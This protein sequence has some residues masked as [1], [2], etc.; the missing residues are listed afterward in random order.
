MRSG[1]VN[2]FAIM[3]FVTSDFRSTSLFQLAIAADEAGDMFRPN[4]TAC[5]VALCTVKSL[6]QCHSADQFSV[7]IIPASSFARSLRKLQ[8]LTPKCIAGKWT[9]EIS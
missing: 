7:D 3:L 1:G 2:K 9:L 5:A 4:K 6:A 8:R